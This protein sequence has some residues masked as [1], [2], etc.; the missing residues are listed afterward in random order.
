MIVILEKHE[1][2]NFIW[3]FLALFFYLEYN[4][5]PEGNW[6]GRKGRKVFQKGTNDLCAILN[7][8]NCKLGTRKS[9]YLSCHVTFSRWWV[10]Q[11]RSAHVRSNLCHMI[12]WRHWMG[13]RA[14]NYLIFF[15]EDLF[16]AKKNIVLEGIAN[17]GNKLKI[18]V[19][20][21]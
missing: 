12:C 21:G 5:V 6:R 1:I 11:V 9:Y 18:N 13:S 16:F 2:E 8:R 3:T 20:N 17:Q 10:T 19:V 7:Q 14:I 4:Q 15:R